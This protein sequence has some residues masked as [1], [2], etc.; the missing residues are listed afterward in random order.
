[1]IRHVVFKMRKRGE[2]IQGVLARLIRESWMR[3]STNHRDFHLCALNF[4]EN[5]EGSYIHVDT[6]DDTTKTMTGWYVGWFTNHYNN[7]WVRIVMSDEPILNIASHESVI[8]YLVYPQD[9]VFVN[10]KQLIQG[11]LSKE[12]Q[13]SIIESEYDDVTLG[14]AADW[15]EEQ[16]YD[17]RILRPKIFAK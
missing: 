17:A 13:E 8:K 4:Y 14:I 1:M 12:W 3:L 10:R 9:L 15:L 16:G 6:N 11:L 2:S 7:K 5:P